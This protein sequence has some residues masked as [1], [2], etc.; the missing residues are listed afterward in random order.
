MGKW[1]NIV[2][3][4]LFTN[5]TLYVT[6]LERS[7]NRI[8]EKVTLSPDNNK[9][10]VV[11]DYIFLQSPSNNSILTSDN[12]IVFDIDDSSLLR[13]DYNWDSQPNVTWLPPYI[14]Q[15]PPGDGV[16]KLN[17]YALDNLD[18]WE[19][20]KFHFT[21]DDTIPIIQLESAVNNS[22]QVPNAL[23]DLIINDSNIERV[24]Y[25]WNS[26]VNQSIVFPFQV[27]LPTAD[28]D[29][30]LSVYVRDAAGNWGSAKY[31]FT[32]QVELSPD[33]DNDGLSDYI[34]FLL[35]TDPTQITDSITGA[36]LVIH[37]LQNDT[38]D[39]LIDV[40]V[41]HDHIPAQNWIVGSISEDGLEDQ[42]DYY[43][44]T[45]E[46]RTTGIVF[47]QSNL[48]GVKLHIF[49]L[50]GRV[51]STDEF[52]LEKLT[53]G[54]GAALS[55]AI[56][57]IPNAMPY[58]V[59]IPIPLAVELLVIQID[60]GYAGNSIYSLWI[61]ENPVQTHIQFIS[62]LLSLILFIGLP[63][64]FFLILRWENRRMTKKQRK[65]EEKL[66]LDSDFFVER[67]ISKKLPPIVKVRFSEWVFSSFILLIMVLLFTE[68][69]REK[70]LNQVTV[71]TAKGFVDLGY[72][73]FF[74]AV[75]MIVLGGILSLFS[76]GNNWF[77]SQSLAKAQ[78]SWIRRFL[79]IGM[80]IGIILIGYF[81]LWTLFVRFIT[82][83][84]TYV[85]S[86]SYLTDVLDILKA[87]FVEDLS[88]PPT[89]DQFSLLSNMGILEL[90]FIVFALPLALYMFIL[91]FAGG[92]SVRKVFQP[93]EQKKSRWNYKTI[94]LGI[95]LSIEIYRI[96]SNL[97]NFLISIFFSENASFFFI[98]ISEL[99]WWHQVVTW[100]SQETLI[101]TPV[102][103]G[104]YFELQGIF[105]A[106][107]IYTSLPSVFRRFMSGSG[108][109]K[110][111]TRIGFF[112]LGMFVIFLRTLHLL[113]LVPVGV[114][115]FPFS[116]ILTDP[117]S[118][119]LLIAMISESL[120]I[121]GFSFG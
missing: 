62:L 36:P 92:T 75:T 90:I 27:N 34:E 94:I 51:N 31:H 103:Y 58:L 98:Q 4:L 91:N 57:F 105:F 66:E 2:I 29:H 10:A 35:G 87:F 100:I 12:E 59:E 9:M 109:S 86:S 88:T 81:I 41:S 71:L 70:F 24:I 50:E 40:L 99:P 32:V 6:E 69:S 119:L 84:E 111:I 25:N 46:I 68:L 117:F 7:S 55:T 3:L 13:V 82:V 8:E 33:S 48:P 121:L 108:Y 49:D 47:L 77:R 52:N 28:G 39:D 23:I 95:S 43:I 18:I 64:M 116:V 104:L 21:V 45:S 16:H 63:F 89:P 118:I 56:D 65:L 120:E 79:N 19:Y 80:K 93:V 67:S 97:L 20:Q 30:Q 22:Q 74:L 38:P 44:F 96:F 5:L 114:P 54:N 115:S 1:T 102:L 107:V 78:I 113:L 72:R 101:S 11:A 112:L 61:E 60:G 37:D 14:T 73:I 76:W 110:S 83:I 15:L 85:S 42:T 17:V 106:W 26:D 53:S